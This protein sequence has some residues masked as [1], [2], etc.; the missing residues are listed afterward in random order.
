[1]MKQLGKFLLIAIAC[2]S[3]GCATVFDGSEQTVSFNSTPP[4]ANVTGGGE[5]DRWDGA[6]RGWDG[7]GRPG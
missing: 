4:G 6:G 5:A 2:L 3:F 1:M 7:V